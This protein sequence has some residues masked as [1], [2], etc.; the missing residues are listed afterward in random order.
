MIKMYFKGKEK[1]TSWGPWRGEERG[2][3][4]PCW[5]P[6]PHYCLPCLAPTDGFQLPDQVAVARRR[7]L[8]RRFELRRQPTPGPMQAHLSSWP[9]SSTHRCLVLGLGATTGRFP[10]LAA[11][12]QPWWNLKLVSSSCLLGHGA[13]IMEDKLVEVLE[14]WES[15]EQG[16]MV[17]SSENHQTPSKCLSGPSPSCANAFLGGHW[18]LLGPAELTAHPSK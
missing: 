3:P 4:R 15:E 9:R 6:V 18:G 2:G 14:T 11:P 16:C 1:H 13:S 17:A 12:W 8:W 10:H 5:M 7:G